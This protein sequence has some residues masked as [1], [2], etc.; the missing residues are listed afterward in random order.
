MPAAAGALISEVV[1]RTG[2]PLGVVEEVGIGYDSQVSMAGKTQPFHQLAYVPFYRP[3]R[4]H[5]IVNAAVKIL[6]A[7]FGDRRPPLASAFRRSTPGFRRT[8]T[9][10]A[11]GGDLLLG[12]SC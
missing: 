4:L 8:H 5:F 1:E 6:R 11:P 12:R 2:Y 9:R 10:T 7:R 3:F